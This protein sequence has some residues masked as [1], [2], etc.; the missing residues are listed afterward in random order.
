[1]TDFEKATPEQ[2]V[3]MWGPFV[4]Q[5]GTYEIKDDVLTL[6]I[7]VAKN[8]GKSGLKQI[9]RFKFQGDTLITEPIRA[10]PI[11]LKLVRVE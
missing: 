4:A 7:L 6:T 1:M 3:A 8:K 5:F 2:L 10:K 11:T 9:E